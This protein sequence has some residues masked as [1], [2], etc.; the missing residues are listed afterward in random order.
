MPMMIVTCLL[1]VVGDVDWEDKDN[2]GC[3][4]TKPGPYGEDTD[5]DNDD[6]EDQM[7]T[8]RTSLVIQPKE[9]LAAL[10]RTRIRGPTMSTIAQESLGLQKLIG[11]V[12]KTVMVTDIQSQ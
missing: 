4:D 3:H 6:V 7:T 11:T 9:N 10:I 2:D 12:V 8:A 5:D 1:S